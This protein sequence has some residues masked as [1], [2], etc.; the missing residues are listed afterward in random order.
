MKADKCKYL[1]IEHGSLDVVVNLPV[2]PLRLHTWAVLRTLCS[3]LVPA[4][5][6]RTKITGLTLT[7]LLIVIF[8]HVM[9]VSLLLLCREIRKRVRMY[10]GNSSIHNYVE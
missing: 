1:S 5:V 10:V 7:S 4:V 8:I 9:A 2:L 3:I 6:T